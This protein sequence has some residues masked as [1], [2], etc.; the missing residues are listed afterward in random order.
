MRL[1]R[2][3]RSRAAVA[4]V[5]SPTR[6]AVYTRKSTDEG[7]DRDFSSL[8]NQRERAE[9]YAASQGWTAVATRYDDGGF[10]GG[11][12][13]RPALK[14][15]LAD[16]EAGLVDAIVVYRLD[17]LSRSLADFVGLHRFLEKHGVALV[18]VT[19]SINT[20]TPHGRMMVNVLLSF[21]QY[22]RELVA[23]RTRHKIEASRRRGKWTGGRPVLGFD[24]VPE[25]GRI[26]VNKDEAEQVRSIFQ[27][28]TETPSLIAVAQEL[29]RR[30]WR[31][32]T[33]VA[34]TGRACGGSWNRVTL[35]RLLT[36]PLYTGMQKLGTETFPGEHPAI[37]PR[38]LFDQVQ[39][40][41]ADSRSTG[42]AGV[43]NGH[44]CLLRGL[45]R[46]TACE[47][48]MTPGWSRSRARLYRY[49][50]CVHAEKNGHAACPTKSVRADKVEQFV[51]DQIRRI[52]TDPE[53]QQATFEQAL[54]QIKAQRRG[55]RAEA[56]RLQRDLVTTRS[57]VER[58][59]GALSRTTGPAADAIAAELAKVQE[60]VAALEARQREVEAEI[61]ALAAQDVDREAVARALRE[62]DELWSVLLTPERERV[63]K[64]LVDRIDYGGGELTIQWRLAGFGQLASEVAP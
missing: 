39:R 12:V 9:N 42:S 1:V 58:L 18:S 55:L 5:T 51:V 25:G 23:E 60:R 10:S 15:L 36:D 14:R 7:L 3:G 45:L 26:V 56:K 63:L 59:V 50:R 22:E 43:R 48:A 32:K 17:R 29:S 49:Y 33:W 53:L 11:N 47:A 46:C 13:E 44:G 6:C 20:Q 41:L 30:G 38:K 37:V 40:L 54:A 2:N 31:P 64:L 35:H 21:A 27:L 57:D 4:T 62:W 34:K 8:D 28:F 52:G 16:V 19:E 61:A 24:T